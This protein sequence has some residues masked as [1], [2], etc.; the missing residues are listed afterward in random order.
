M[1]KTLPST[2]KF[3]QLTKMATPNFKNQKQPIMSQNGGFL[4]KAE[5]SICSDKLKLKME[6]SSPLVLNQKER[7]PLAE[8]VSDCA[9]R[10]FR[11][12]LKEA[13]AGDTA[14]QV[15]LAQMYFSG[16][17]IPKDPKMGKIW[18]NKASKVRSAALKVGDK[19]PGYVASDSDS[20][21]LADEV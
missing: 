8:I 14:M 21:E 10:W 5:T 13:K 15:L 1:G 7:V 20:E 19:R 2:T 12:T 6:S 17:G 16:Y 9:K 3:H 11:D 18:I 4:S